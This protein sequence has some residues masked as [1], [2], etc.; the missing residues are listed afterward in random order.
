MRNRIVTL[1]RQFAAITIVFLVI[2][3]ITSLALRSCSTSYQQDQ[4]SKPQVSSSIPPDGYGLYESC[5]PRR[6]S[7]CLDRLK[8]MAAG[9][10][11]LVLNYDQLVGS[12]K[13]QL[14]YAKQASALGMKIIWAMNNPAVWDGTNQINYYAELAATCNCSDNTSFIRYVVH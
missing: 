6:G 3:A 4:S 12:A 14:A 11:K 9:G 10:F 2:I 5:L 7:F 8:Q 1:K 13:E